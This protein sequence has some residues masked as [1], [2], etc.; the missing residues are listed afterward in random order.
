MK[1][2]LII[3]P[4]LPYP[5][6][7]G[8]HQAIFNGISAAINNAEVYLTY[9]EKEPMEAGREALMNLFDNRITILPYKIKS[10][11]EKNNILDLIY[12]LKSH[13]KKILTGKSHSTPKEM[14]YTRWIYQLLPKSNDYISHI[15]NIIETQKIDIVQCEMLDTLALV[16]SIPKTIKTIFIQHEIGFV[17]KA[18][19]PCLKIK[20][21]YEGADNL[22][23]NKQLEV[24]LLNQFDTVVAL[25]DTDAEKMKEAGVTTNILSSFAIVNSHI[26]KDSYYHGSSILSFC[27]PEWHYPNFQ[28]LLWFL[29][30]CW[31][32]L[33]T[34]DNSY[35]MVV[36]GNWTEKTKQQIS[37][38]F[39]DVTFSG[40]VDDLK[41]I[42]H[43]TIM[44]VPITIGSGIRMKIL[45]AGA[46]GIP[47]VTTSV[48]A[49]GLP[50][51]N[52]DHCFIADSPEDF[53]N[54]IL[55]LKDTSLGNRFI[56]NIRTIVTSKY[57]LENL[58]ENRKAL[59]S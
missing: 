49:E 27:G 22:E 51:I 56:S 13:I 25:S 32:K 29:N 2:L 5:L 28:G 54:S 15:L 10:T 19:H 58:I 20:N 47:V 50:L 16:L 48:G 1:R 12:I 4:F 26:E 7:S 6:I 57:N 53:L 40:Y 46:L 37:S 24:F 30:N 9:P 14:P 23:L 8:G 38:K 39:S 17:R 31:D 35:S 45:E 34:I 59:Y 21:N 33:K 44:I 42:L 55:S 11:K 43:G 3:S 52:G 41:D 36:I 18:L